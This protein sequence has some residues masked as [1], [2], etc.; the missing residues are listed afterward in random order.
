MASFFTSRHSSPALLINTLL[1][2]G[3]VAAVQEVVLAVAEQRILASLL[4]LEQI[5]DV[6][7]QLSLIQ[8][9]GAMVSHPEIVKQFLPFGGVLYMC[10]L[11]ANSGDPNVRKEAASLLAKAMQDRL[12]GPRVKISVLF[13]FNIF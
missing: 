1:I 13:F 2:F 9:L 6:Q 4:L 3:V 11:F 8:V 12:S 10:D 5:I 7:H